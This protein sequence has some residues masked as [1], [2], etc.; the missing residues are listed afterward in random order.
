[1]PLD[2]AGGWTPLGSCSQQ[3]MQQWID[4]GAAP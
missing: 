2:D 4:L 1:M 3:L